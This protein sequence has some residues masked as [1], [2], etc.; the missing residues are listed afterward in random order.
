MTEPI[1]SRAAIE[2]KARAAAK[3]YD[4][5]NDACPYPF[6]T[7]AGKVFKAEFNRARAEI[8]E[9]LKS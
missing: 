7:E 6:A 4:N 3:T 8:N 2:A 1:I 9:R 5:V